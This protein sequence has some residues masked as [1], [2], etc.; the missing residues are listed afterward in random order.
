[1]KTWK[2]VAVAAAGAVLG[3][4][5]FATY[6]GMRQVDPREYGWVMNGKD[7][8]IEYSGWQ[9]FRLE[10][11][12]W[13]PGRINSLVF[14]VG[15]SIANADQGLRR[16]L[17]DGPLDPTAVYVVHPSA[18]DAFTAAHGD[19]IRCRAVDGVYACMAPALMPPEPPPGPA[20]ESSSAPAAGG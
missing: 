5:F 17:A 19:Q 11:W 7:I 2:H 20:E 14:P 13:P 4:I 12:Q 18:L 16:Q 3:F 9:A 1:M 10:P 8:R 6:E 15:T